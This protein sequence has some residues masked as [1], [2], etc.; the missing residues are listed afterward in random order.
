MTAPLKTHADLAERLN[1]PLSTTIELR[2]REGWPHIRLG[3]KVRFTD[4][5]IDQIIATHTVVE[6]PAVVE[7]PFGPLTPRARRRGGR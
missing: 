7:G 6:A 2:K 4:E 1:L 5:Q 3:R